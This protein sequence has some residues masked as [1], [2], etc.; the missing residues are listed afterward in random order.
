[1]NL[2]ASM[3]S[4]FR[5]PGGVTVTRKSGPGAYVAG[6]FVPAASAAPFVIDPASVQPISGREKLQL[7]EADRTLDNVVIFTKD[8]L[9]VDDVVAIPGFA[10][11]FEIHAVE[12]WVD[13]HLNHYQS[14]GVR[15]GAD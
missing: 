5:I 8:E 2:S 1:M 11:T 6:R 15:Q 14:R 9:M 10:G 13:K 12:T 3:I 4:E 7:P